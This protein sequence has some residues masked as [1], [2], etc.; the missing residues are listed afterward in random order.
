MRRRECITLVGAATV[1]PFAARAQQSALP[2]IGFL[3]VA[4]PGGV[5]NYA[6]AFRDGL[7]EI[8]YVDGQNVAIEYRWAGGHYVRLAEKAADLGRRQGAVVCANTPCD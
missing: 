6:A 2:I 8:G 4:S 7:K 3:N 1:W 5:A